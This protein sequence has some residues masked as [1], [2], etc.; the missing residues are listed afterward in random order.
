MALAAM[1]YGSRAGTMIS[2]HSQHLWAHTPF[3]WRILQ[4][5]VIIILLFFSF[6]SIY[7]FGPSLKDPEMAME[8]ARRACSNRVV[9]RFY[10]AASNLSG[11]LQ[12]V[13]KN[14]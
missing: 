5:P 2:Q 10:H 4:W 8:H 13:P 3:P 9:G 14:L 7:R 11:S 6:G 12:F 1:L